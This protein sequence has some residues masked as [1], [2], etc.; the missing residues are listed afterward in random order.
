LYDLESRMQLGT[1]TG[2]GRNEEHAKVTTPFEKDIEV[3]RH[4]MK[5]ERPV[6]KGNRVVVLRGDHLGTLGTVD[7]RSAKHKGKWTV[8]KHST[9]DIFAVDPKDLASID[10]FPNMYYFC[11]T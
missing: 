10:R 1:I 8:K 5:V 9:N 6:G 2:P 7:S 3:P 11:T 4:H